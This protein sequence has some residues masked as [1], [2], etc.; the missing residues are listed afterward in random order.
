MK[1]AP[2]NQ[3]QVGSR[4]KEWADPCAAPWVDSVRDWPAGAGGWRWCS[5]VGQASRLETAAAAAAATTAEA[6]R[7]HRARTCWDPL[8]PWA[9]ADAARTSGWA[10]TVVAEAGHLAAPAAGAS[11]APAAG[12]A[13]G[14]S[15]TA[16]CPRGAAAASAAGTLLKKKT[17]KQAIVYTVHASNTQHADNAPPKPQCD[18]ST[19]NYHAKL[20]T[21]NQIPQN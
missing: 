9:V 21:L 20:I 3:Y 8:R 18:I 16:A 1:T 5:S 13:R 17:K 14:S 10:G 11:T 12:T 6:G 2:S 4:G 15:C 7:T 19:R